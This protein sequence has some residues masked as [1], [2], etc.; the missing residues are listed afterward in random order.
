VIAKRQGIPLA[1]V[2]TRRRKESRF[3][4]SP[5]GD[6]VGCYPPGSCRMRPSQIFC[7]FVAM[8]LHQEHTRTA[9]PAKRPHSTYIQAALPLRLSVSARQPPRRSSTWE[10]PRRS[11]DRHNHVS[12]CPVEGEADLRPACDHLNVPNPPR[13]EIIGPNPSRCKRLPSRC[14]GSLVQLWPSPLSQQAG[15]ASA[16][17]NRS[18]V[19][20]TGR[21]LL[22]SRLSSGPSTR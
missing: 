13:V 12:H 18:C 17:Q 3:H 10:S 5:D 9:R 1:L 14:D 21:V 11:F 6:R 7:P 22:L 15:R 20:R 16:S 2:A 4:E 8:E 19:G